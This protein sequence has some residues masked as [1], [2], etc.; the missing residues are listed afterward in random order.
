MI[1]SLARLG[2]LRT[3]SFL[4]IIE[5]RDRRPLAHGRVIVVMEVAAPVQIEHV[6][7]PR[8]LAVVLRVQQV[9]GE[10]RRDLAAFHDE[11]AEVGR[12]AL[13]GARL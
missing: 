9:L 10:G 11:L 5:L 3:A 12:E 6:V 8:H 2:F 7:D 1:H 13:V 4:E